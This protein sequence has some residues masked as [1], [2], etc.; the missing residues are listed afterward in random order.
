MPPALRITFG[1]QHLGMIYG[2]LYVGVAIFEPLWSLL[3]QKT[4]GCVGVECYDLYTRSSTC[5][6]L[7][8]L[9]ATWAV[10]RQQTRGMSREALLQCS[11]G[12]LPQS[13]AP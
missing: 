9:L 6:L 7:I 11:D 3:F 4:E 10:L 13:G 12:N 1:T 2:L 8:T 5:A